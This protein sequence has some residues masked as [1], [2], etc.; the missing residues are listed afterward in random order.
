MS[1]IE[2]LRQLRFGGYAV[3]DFTISLIGIYLLSPLLSK[4][5]HKLGLDVPRENWL[6]LTL[7]ISI[8]AHMLVGKI[9]PMTR[10]F[11]DLH[12]HYLLKVVILVLLI[13]GLRGIKFVK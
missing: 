5:F 3:F 13:I 7:P 4:L 10:D 11:F 1:P 2:Y 6:F 12:N 9:T 8:F